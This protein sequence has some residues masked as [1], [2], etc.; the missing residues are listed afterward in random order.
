MCLVFQL[1]IKSGREISDMGSPGCRRV[2][3]RQ[4]TTMYWP[5]VFNQLG[6]ENCPI[7]TS[8]RSRDYHPESSII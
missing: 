2:V 8:E 5:L 6:G 3:P 7:W 4:Q 1:R